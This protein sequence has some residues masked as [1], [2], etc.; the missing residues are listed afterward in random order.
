MKRLALVLAGL[1]IGGLSVVG[2][3]DAYCHYIDFDRGTLCQRPDDTLWRDPSAGCTGGEDIECQEY[4][5]AE[6]CPDSVRLSEDWRHAC[7]WVFL[8][9]EYP[10]SGPPP[11]D[12]G[13]APGQGVPGRSS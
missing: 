11:Y 10:P 8:K 5:E 9:V 13:P 12:E 6:S 3:H 1:L 2:G 4:A 7:S